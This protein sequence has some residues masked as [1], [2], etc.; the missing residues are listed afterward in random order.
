MN[1]QEPI[2]KFEQ[3]S[4]EVDK[5]LENLYNN[6]DEWDFA[7]CPFRDWYDAGISPKV[8]AEHAK[9]CAKNIF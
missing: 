8:A 3:W 2:D 5:H 6:L 7:D 1:E 4:K 9:R